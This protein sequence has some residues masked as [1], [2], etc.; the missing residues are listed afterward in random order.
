[1]RKSHGI[2]HFN[3]KLLLLAMILVAVSHFVGV[4][5]TAQSDTLENKWEVCGYLSILNI[6]DPHGFD[7]K[8]PAQ[9]QRRT[10]VGFGGRIGYNLYKYVALEGEINFFPR[11]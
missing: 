10:E 7:I 4:E 11:D 2:K 1:M 8:Y 9:P 5:L 6:S 3:P